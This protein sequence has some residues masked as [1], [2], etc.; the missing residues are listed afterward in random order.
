MHVKLVWFLGA[1]L[2]KQVQ[3]IRN[4]TDTQRTRKRTRRLTTHVQPRTTTNGTQIT[5]VNA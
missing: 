1:C 2:G 5:M 3:R 4:Y